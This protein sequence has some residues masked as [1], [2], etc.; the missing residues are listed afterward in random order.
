M[1]I[2]DISIIIVNYKSW[3]PLDKCLLSIKKIKNAIINVEVIIVDNCSNDDKFDQYSRLYSDFTFLLNKGNFGFANGCNEGAKIAKGSYLLFLNP[4]AI[5]SEKVLI[6]FLK[7]AKNNSAYK[8]LSCSKMNTQGK[9]ENS[10]K[11]LPSLG[12]L[13]GLTRVFK[14]I[15]SKKNTKEKYHNGFNILFPEWISGSLVFTSRE[16]FD[17]IKGWNQD[18][19]MYYEDVDLCKRTLEEKGKIVLIKNLKILHDHGG[20]SRINVKTTALTKSE[21][22]ISRHVYIN[23]HFKGITR[24]IA[25]ITLVAG[26]LI[27][28]TI[29]AV[30]GFIFFFVPKILV[31]LYLYFNI[32]AYYFHA[33]IHNTWL[34]KRSL[35]YK[36][37]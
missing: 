9:L 15:L 24:I 17:Y 36:R 29:L 25:Q 26:I 10:N 13:F 4:D 11:P 37:L 30:L 3:L 21:V 28:K 12:S 34:S 8:L 19:W 31:N 35:N 5:V 32:I 20:A 7:I 2:P 22:I 33:I 27:E 18:Y 6:N 16:W 23:N 14:R 1:S